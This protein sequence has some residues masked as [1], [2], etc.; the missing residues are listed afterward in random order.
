M[1]EAFKSAGSAQ[2]MMDECAKI[3]ALREEDPARI[4]NPHWRDASIDSYRRRTIREAAQCYH[5]R[6]T[7]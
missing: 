2:K 5:R 1:A 4:L 7:Q 6:L 3:T